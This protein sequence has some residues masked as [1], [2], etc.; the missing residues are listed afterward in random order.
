VHFRITEETVRRSL[1]EGMTL[2]AIQGVLETHSRTPVPQNVSFSIRDWALRAGLMRLAPDLLLRCEDS[3]TLRR[4]LADPG[5]RNFIGEVADA[6][7]VRLSGRITA[8]RMQALLR[9]LGY[10][11]EMEEALG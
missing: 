11:V 10:L 6:R 4:F 9:D 5:T 7:T 8:R 1:K 3:E 2:S